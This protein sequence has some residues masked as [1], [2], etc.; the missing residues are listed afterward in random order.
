MT[1]FDVNNDSLVEA[2]PFIV[3]DVPELILTYYDI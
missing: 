3:I 1:S 2:N